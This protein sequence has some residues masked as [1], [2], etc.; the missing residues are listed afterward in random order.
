MM[1]TPISSATKSGVWVG[2]VPAPAGTLF[3]L[4]KAPASARVGIGQPKAG[5][6]HRDAAGDV[7]KGVLALRPA[8][9]LPLLFP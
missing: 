2:K 6:Q 8:K 5:D 7:V 1:I 9:A 4:A 3:F